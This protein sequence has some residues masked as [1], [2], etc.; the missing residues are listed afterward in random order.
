MRQPFS[1]SDAG[2]PAD[3]EIVR[4]LF[5]AYQKALDVDLCFQGFAGE[6]AGLP[7]QYAAPSGAL[8]L[9]RNEHGEALGCVALRSC[10][11]VGMCEMKRLYVTPEA[12]GLGV[13]TALLEAILAAARAIGYRDIRLDTLP[14]MT[15]ARALYAKAGFKPIPPYYDSPIAG[16]AFLA[17]PLAG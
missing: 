10:D 13:G 17:K 3:I 1:I 9:A 2:G 11:G 7:G 12:R 5:L 6:L 15:A 8:L 4:G 16:T 14:Q